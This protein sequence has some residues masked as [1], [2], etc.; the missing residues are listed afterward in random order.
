[1][2]LWLRQVLAIAVKEFLTDPQ[3]P[4]AAASS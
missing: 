4:S 1:M 3:G 2:L